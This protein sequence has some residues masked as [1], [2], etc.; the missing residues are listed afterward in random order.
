MPASLT[1]ISITGPSLP[2]PVSLSRHPQA[3]SASSYAQPSN[4]ASS[5]SVN[6]ARWGASQR[7]SLRSVGNCRGTWSRVPS[8][9]TGRSQSRSAWPQAGSGAALAE[10]ER[11]A[12]SA[13]RKASFSGHSHQSLDNAGARRTGSFR[14]SQT[15][16]FSHVLQSSKAADRGS[17]ELMTVHSSVD[18]EVKHVPQGASSGSAALDQSQF[19]QTVKLENADKRPLAIQQ[20]KFE[21]AFS[22]TS[23]SSMFDKDQTHGS[24]QMQR[25]HTFAESREAFSPS[26]QTAQSTL[27]GSFLS[28]GPFSVQ[29]SGS[30]PSTSKSHMQSPPENNQVNS[31]GATVFRPGTI[32]PRQTPTEDSKKTEQNVSQPAAQQSPLS[33]IEFSQTRPIPEDSLIPVKPLQFLH[34][35]T[36]QLDFSSPPKPIEH[37]LNQPTSLGLFSPVKPIDWTSPHAMTVDLS[38]SPR[39]IGSSVDHPTSLGLSSPAKPIDFTPWQPT[40]A[41]LSSPPGLVGSSMDQPMTLGLISP[42]KP[43]KFTPS[44]SMAANLSSPPGPVGSSMEQPMTLGLASPPKPIEF[45]PSSPTAANLSSPPW[46]YWVLDRPANGFGHSLSSEAHRIHPI[47][48]DGS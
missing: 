19:R 37:L 20:L 13:T 48:A 31:D 17:R 33:S 4:H 24:I 46:A 8:L 22:P 41:N 25:G 47:I 28:P 34:S 21:S 32:E 27:Y 15:A 29:R 6:G 30:D 14:C 10:H 36:M 26:V 1:T 2:K 16:S 40:A 5:C 42:P 11:Q 35:P 18:I 3:V 45:T 7:T 44:P 23:L 9:M 38:S 43:I 39:P 12:F